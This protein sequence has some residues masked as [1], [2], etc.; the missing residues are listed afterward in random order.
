MLATIVYVTGVPGTSEAAPS[1][2]VIA[3]SVCGVSV[4]V[5]VA[6]LLPGVGSVVAAVIVAV[7][8]SEPV[9]SAAMLQVAV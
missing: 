3:R 6:L 7:L 2:L 4:S 8:A 9:A 1:V 5:S